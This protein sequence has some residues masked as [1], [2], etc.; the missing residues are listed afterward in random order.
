MTSLLG[1]LVRSG[2][3]APLSLDDW[4]GMFS[5]NGLFYPGQQ[6]AQTTLGEKAEEIGGDFMGVV[7]GAYKANGVVFACMVARMLLFSEARFQFRQVRNGRPGDLFGTK[8]LERLERP[9]PGGTTGDMLGRAMQDSDLAGNWYGRQMPGGV[10]RMRPDW[11]TI[12]LGSQSAPQNPAQA[13]DSEI[14]G[15]VYHPGGR[16]SG[17]KPVALLREE[18]A[19]FAP[20]PDPLASYR[21]MSWL[22][23]VVRE[24]MGDSAA[25]THKLRF[26]ENGAT[27][28]LVVTLDEKVKKAQFDEWVEAFEE[29]HKGVL[30]AYKTLY[31]GGGADVTPVGANM[32]EV[33]FTDVQGHGETRIA[34]AAG[35]PPVI[36][37]L[38]EG[39][40]AATYSNYG[41][42]CRRFADGTMRPLWRNMAGSLATIV[43]VPS[44]AEL[45]YDDRDIPFLQED[46]KDAAEIR[47]TD[48]SSV[49]TLVD[50]GFE[51]ASVIEAV[52]ADDLSRLSHTGLFSVQLQPPNPDGGGDPGADAGRALA[53]LLAPHLNGNSH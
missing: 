19:H 24:I 3:D 5:F 39:L 43:D 52:T 4:A 10:H 37:G 2:D 16:G 51:P 14:L 33:D 20:I 15:Y 49:K 31:L 50:A 17:E 21:G 28:N 6:P 34:A 7:Q 26:F 41:Q 36:V 1:S 23:P 47:Q 40:Q 13:I 38:S 22:T 9:W 32:R 8:A 27:V 35:T 25:S 45:W 12:V 29:N 18:V 42:A 53:Q 30:N 48:A 11:V 44:S 46:V